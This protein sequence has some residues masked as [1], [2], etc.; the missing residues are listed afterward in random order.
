MC[1]G[2]GHIGLAEAGAQGRGPAFHMHTQGEDHHGIRSTSSQG[3]HQE[4]AP[5][6]GH[7]GTQHSKP[8]V[9]CSSTKHSTISPIA[10]S[11]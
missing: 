11:L 3:V 7:M 1:C 10:L 6:L 8:R 5:S 2:Q 9:L 4:H